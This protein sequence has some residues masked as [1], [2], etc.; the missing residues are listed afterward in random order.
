MNGAPGIIDQRALNS[1]LDNIG[2]A[3]TDARMLPAM[4][5]GK[6]EGFRISEVKPGVLFASVGLKNGDL[7]VRINEF[8]LDSPEKATQSL[9]ALEGQSRRKL[10]LVREGSPATMT[11]DIR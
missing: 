2:Q 6:V 9:M 4:K 1:A 11:Y 8:P 5:D 3:M 10:D 7:L